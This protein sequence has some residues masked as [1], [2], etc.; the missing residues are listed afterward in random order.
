MNGFDELANTLSQ[1]V[2]AEMAENFFGARSRLDALLEGFQV[3]AG[4]LRA[5]Q[6]QAEARF[7]VLHHL[8]LR[9]RE[10]R[11]FYEAIGVDPD[12]TG[13]AEPSPGSSQDGPAFGL[14]LS[15]RYFKTVLAA[16]A[17]ARSEAQDFMHGRIYVDT[18]DRGRRKL[19]VHYTQ[20]AEL[21]AQVNETIRKV[22]ENLKPSSVIQYVK[23]FNPE[24]MSRERAVGVPSNG[25]S[26]NMDTDL[27]YQ[28]VD[29]GSLG[30]RALPEL[31]EPG[32]VS[33][34]VR[35][36]CSRLCKEQE[37][38]VRAVLAELGAAAA[39]ARQSGKK[40]KK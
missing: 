26:E 7:A 6:G 16:Y 28:P 32:D 25:Y 31:P 2:L 17:E 20:V 9:G 39:S 38:E 8:L 24:R 29:F 19:S 11:A 35:V 13:F 23:K 30:L 18:H 4:Q 12:L 1:E 34:A 14:T 33:P 36:F 5:I 15:G 37:G 22:N 3:L 10:A 27:R 21:H 40:E